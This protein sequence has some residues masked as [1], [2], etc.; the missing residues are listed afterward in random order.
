MAQTW[1][2]L[3]TSHTLSASRTYLNDNFTTLRSSFSGTSFPGSPI[4]GQF[5]YNTTDNF[6]YVY[7]G[8]AWKSI[9]DMD[10][11]YAASLPRGAG[12]SYALWGDLYCGSQ[13][14]KSVASPS[15]AND[16][17]TLTYAQNTLIDGHS[18]TGAANDGPKLN[19]L[20]GLSSATETDWALVGASTS[21][22]MQERVLANNNVTASALF[23]T[24]G[25]AASVAVTCYANQPRYIFCG[26]L[27]EN[28]NLAASATQLRI[29]RTGS[30]IWGPVT[31]NTYAGTTEVQVCG[32]TT[33]YADTPPSSTSYTYALEIYN[34]IT[35]VYARN[36]WITVI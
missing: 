28:L 14:I 18:H 31:Y 9:G 33:C 11:N 16:V 25:T 4:A 29:T 7:N 35:G 19:M 15:A 6:I 20:T 36:R 17:V 2:T 12:S 1:T 13:Q 8:S 22:G 34:N 32:F 3:A 26:C 23:S 24:W 27:L 5:F 30:V 10:Y 21:G